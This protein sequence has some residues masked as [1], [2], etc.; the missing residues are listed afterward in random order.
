MSGLKMN[1][2]RCV[3]AHSIRMRPMDINHTSPYKLEKL[4]L[5]AKRF[6]TWRYPQG[7]FSILS[8]LECCR[9]PSYKLRII[10]TLIKCSVFKWKMSNL[11]PSTWLEKKP[12]G[13][14][15]DVEKWGTLTSILKYRMCDV[16]RKSFFM[17]NSEKVNF[18]CLYGH[19]IAG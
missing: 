11:D 13:G 10:I 3:C 18:Y 17:H 2:V 15:I 4:K 8:S 16:L 19:H 6:F 14:G 1:I 5:W 9:R 7:K 12:I